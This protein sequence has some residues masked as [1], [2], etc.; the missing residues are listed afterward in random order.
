[1]LKPTLEKRLC[2]KPAGVATPIRPTPAAF[3][4]TF[5]YPMAKHNPSTDASNQTPYRGVLSLSAKVNKSPLRGDQN[6][7]RPEDKPV[8]TLAFSRGLDVFPI[9]IIL[10]EAS[11][12]P[13]LAPR[14][15][16]AKGTDRHINQG[17]G[18]GVQSYRQAP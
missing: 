11:W 7:R 15:L 2:P 14:S 1:M 5:A 10:F 4:E 8:K 6:L 17:S 16:P 13:L 3:D 18:K 12:W 9:V